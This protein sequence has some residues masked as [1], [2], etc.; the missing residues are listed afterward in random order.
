VS[1][2]R[3]TKRCAAAAAGV[4]MV[5]ASFAG[6]AA[7]ATASTTHHISPNIVSGTPTSYG[8]TAGAA[9]NVPLPTSGGVT[10]AVAIPT[11]TINDPTGEILSGS[12]VTLTLSGAS[13]AAYGSGGS[14][15]T[16]G[17][18]VSTATPLHPTTT[19]ITF[20]TTSTTSGT[21]ATY[22]VSGL[23]VTGAT[24]AGLLRVTVTVALPSGAPGGSVQPPSTAT[25]VGAVT[26]V[27]TP[28]AGATAPDTAA[29]LFAA[30]FPTAAPTN[31]VVATDYAPQDAESANYLAKA[32]N[33]G[34]VLTDPTTLSTAVSNILTTYPSIAHVYIVGG[35]SVVSSG[36]QA[37]LTTAIAARTGNTVTRYSGATQ[38]DT[39]QAILQAVAGLTPGTQIVSLP[40]ANNALY[41]TSGGL[42]STTA[43]TNT[44]AAG[45]TAILVS[46]SIDSYQDGVASSALSYADTL[47]VIL[48]TPTALSTQASAALSYG[49][50]TQVIVL[51]GPSAISDSVVSGLIAG[52]TS[53]FRVGGADASETASLLAS[54][55]LSSGAITT[56]ISHATTGLNFAPTDGTGVLLAR[57][58]GF[59]D[60]LAAGAYAGGHA[61]V[62]AGSTGYTPILL[63][64]NATTLGGSSTSG[65]TKYL[66][67]LG[68]ASTPVFTIQPIG[69]PLSVTPALT[70]AA[71]NAEVGGVA[72]ASVVA[73]GLPGTPTAVAGAAGSLA[74]TVTVV[75]PTTGGTPTSYTVTAADLTTPGNGGQ[76]C[77]VT[78]AN[79]SCTVTALHGTDHYTFSAT[80]TNAGG[81]SGP[82]GPSAQITAQ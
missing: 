20:V 12:T 58:N 45:K 55:E 15:A 9:V 14:V 62:T 73:P 52:G 16:T 37:S 32:L 64:E 31:L 42:S 53:V 48:T 66:S 38:Y 28:A 30:A 63:S 29:V 11:V 13:G 49:G 50:Y 18:G 33:T 22:A 71:T 5:L 47:P 74:A 8:V 1:S 70:T 65:L 51:G 39:N 25:T 75:A 68:A 61:G 43:P 72:T 35:T 46:G 81:T 44:P 2:I 41:N 6:A 21:A 26:K 4:G 17:S 54:L 69:G 57:G 60:A 79:G 24:A 78:G 7:S 80:A 34:V 10:T 67:A 76:I 19:S 36:V 40:Y 23:T 56:N 82:S 27:A 3:A 59:Q 77:T